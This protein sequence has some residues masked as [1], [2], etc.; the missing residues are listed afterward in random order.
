MA[1]SSDSSGLSSAGTEYTSFDLMSISPDPPIS[2]H[3]SAAVSENASGGSGENVFEDGFDYASENASDEESESALEDNRYDPDPKITVRHLNPASRQRQNLQ[4]P[5]PAVVEEDAD[6]SGKTVP[7]IERI[8][9]LG[10]QPMFM[11]HLPVHKEIPGDLYYLSQYPLQRPEIWI[12]R[13]QFLRI[14]TD[15]L[16]IYLHLT[17]Y[18]QLEIIMQIFTAIQ[19]YT[20]KY[21]TDDFKA[22]RAW[23]LKRQ[24]VLRHAREMFKQYGTIPI[25]TVSPEDRG[26]YWPFFREYDDEQLSLAPST[27]SPN[28]LLN[29]EVETMVVN[30]NEQR[31]EQSITEDLLNGED[32]MDDLK[33][34]EL[35]LNE[36]DT[37]LKDEPEWNFPVRTPP[38]QRTIVCAAPLAMDTNDPIHIK[39]Y[40]LRNR[41]NVS[42]NAGKNM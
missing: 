32:G 13:A 26:Q 30:L 4:G 5:G 6:L 3:E 33:L 24:A 31:C 38:R 10:P 20:F 41:A 39:G 34:C 37:R 12:G 42:V 16:R 18:D 22:L 9:R 25:N 40:P 1:R 8:A 15:D 36:H 19:N 21:E 35:P 27:V 2:E 29:Y 7:T 28:P 14:Y 17:T 11:P 23:A